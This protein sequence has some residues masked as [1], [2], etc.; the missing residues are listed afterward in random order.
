[1]ATVIVVARFSSPAVADVRAV[2]RDWTAAGLVVPPL[3]I[4]ADTLPASGADRHAET[5]SSLVGYESTAEGDRPVAVSTWFATRGVDASGTGVR[6]VCLQPISAAGEAV[7]QGA[8]TG[9]RER[10]ALPALQILNVLSPRPGTVDLPDEII[11][12]S[13]RNVL[14][15]PVD[16][17]DPA[18]A[19]VEVDRA[20]ALGM[21]TA[22]GLCTVAGLWRGVDGAPHD[23]DHPWAGR[24]LQ[25]ARTYLRRL[26]GS[27]VLDGIARAVL[28]DGVHGGLPAARDGQGNPMPV[29]APDQRVPTAEQAAAQLVRSTPVAVY[30]P[31][32]PPR[33]PARKQITPGAALRDFFSFLG[34]ALVKA[35]GEWVRRRVEG[36][37][38]GVSTRLTQALYGEAGAYEVVMGRRPGQAPDV[39]AAAD[40]ALY[41]VRALSPGSELPTPDAQS[42]WRGEVSVATALLDGSSTSLVEMPSR[43]AQRLLIG[44]PAAVAPP[45][46]R[47]PFVVP[48]GLLRTQSALSIP[49]NDPYLAH[50]VLSELTAVEHAAPSW[51]GASVPGPGGPPHGGPGWG[52]PPST[53]WGAGPV[54]GGRAPQ[55][56]AAQAG[57]V[58]GQ[59]RQWIERSRSFTWNISDS[60]ASG[61]RAAQQDQAQLLNVAGSE[62]LS[63]AQDAAEQEA[64]S[65]RKKMLGWVLGLALVTVL[66]VVLAVTGVLGGA[67]LAIIAVAV[68]L[69]WLIGALVTFVRS[70]RRYYQM[71]HALDTISARRRWADENSLQ[72]PMAILRLADVYRRS[73]Q[74]AT[75][76]SALVHDPFSRD[77]RSGSAA[78]GA[79]RLTGDLPFGMALGHLPFAEHAYREEIFRAAATTLV[80]GWLDTTETSR[81]SLALLP[82]SRQTGVREED[83]VWNSDGSEHSALRALLDAQQQ[84]DF[85]RAN[86]DGAMG[87][88]TGHLE[89]VG[90][91]MKDATI[92]AGA[93]QRTVHASEFVQQL[94]RASP[95]PSQEGVSAA[96]VQSG[97]AD[98]VLTHFWGIPGRSGE[99][100]DTA[101]DGRSTL[102]R[103]V[104]HPVPRR[105]GRSLLDQQVVRC[106]LTRM[107]SAGE[108]VYFRSSAAGGDEG[109]TAVGPSG[110]PAPDGTGPLPTPR[111][112]A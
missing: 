75:A 16:A 104:V 1:M 105:T 54:P 59:L 57:M 17:E 101:R 12:D 60:I 96:G 35:P 34:G 79:V 102:R 110:V 100:T 40:G 109:P 37:Q 26:D 45:P 31:L 80:P 103:V 39:Q 68:L 89:S 71:I 11:F 52:A 21:H 95:V 22:A 19:P 10:I 6:L 9:V 85:R 65:T 108:L 78:D 58:A 30:V 25:V 56:R 97:A 55:A 33:E 99:V 62:E 70:S 24:R 53:G 83:V 20:G 86:A 50:Q 64:R 47:E 5:G 69:G 27:D 51:G 111:S 29:V 93:V 74:W 36:F 49:A 43:G 81:R 94:V 2:V 87:W 107:L 77:A 98:V 28:D 63:A 23:T 18:A 82:R 112:R 90:F 4:D 48:A 73:R 32:P 15:Q 92:D 7:P 66:V 91:D 13:H 88:L 106:D 46:G 76:I 84:P 44:D 38:Q 72:V 41:L 3:W 14:L 8:V 42:L 61:L 67:L